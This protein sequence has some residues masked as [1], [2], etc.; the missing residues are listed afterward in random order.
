MLI[1]F[2]Y[3]SLGNRGQQKLYK[4]SSDTEREKLKVLIE[5]V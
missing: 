3:G 5:K 1:E 2:Q 4:E